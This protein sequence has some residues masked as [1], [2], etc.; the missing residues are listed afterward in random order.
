MYNWP[1]I[2][3]FMYQWSFVMYSNTIKHA[4]NIIKF[5][6]WYVSSLVDCGVR[7]STSRSLKHSGLFPFFPVVHSDH[8]LFVVTFACG[9]WSRQR[10]GCIYLNLL[11]WQV[12]QHTSVCQKL[13]CPYFCPSLTLPKTQAFMWIGTTPTTPTPGVVWGAWKGVRG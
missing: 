2:A 10:A 7:T 12:Y 8:K 11:G 5:C 13:V 6:Q 1:G 9:S 3:L 4:L